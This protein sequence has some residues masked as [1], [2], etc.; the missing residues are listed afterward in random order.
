L[1]VGERD[2]R[3]RTLAERARA[4]LPSAELAVV[5]RA[6]HTVHLDQPTDFVRVVTDVV[7]DRARCR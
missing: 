1:I 4:L 3:Y 7:A 6:G 5:K 2:A